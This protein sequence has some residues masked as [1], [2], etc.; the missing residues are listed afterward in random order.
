MTSENTEVL[1]AFKK[2]EQEIAKEVLA[3]KTEIS[4]DELEF[5]QAVKIE[6]KEAKISLRKA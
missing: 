5:S 6:G 1:D 3:A 2:F 4:N